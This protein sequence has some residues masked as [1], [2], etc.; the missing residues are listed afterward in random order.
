MCNKTEFE[1]EGWRKIPPLMEILEKHV[2]VKI[3]TM[4][5]ETKQIDAIISLAQSNSALNSK[6]VTKLGNIRTIKSSWI[7]DHFKNKDTKDNK[8]AIYVNAVLPINKH[9]TSEQIESVGNHCVVVKGLTEW[10]NDDNKKIECLELENNGGCEETKFIPVD[11]PFFEHVRVEVQKILDKGSETHER[12]LNKTGEEL[13]K[14]KW[15]K[16][17]KNWFDAKKKVKGNQKKAEKEQ[18][19][20]QMLF[21]RAVHPCFGLKFTS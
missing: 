11:H 16:L 8:I 4:K 7:Y 2:S 6:D 20:Y 13:A 14:A 18:D 3:P 5:L 17:E 1:V 9:L 19:R 10:K 21:V 12:A 15:G